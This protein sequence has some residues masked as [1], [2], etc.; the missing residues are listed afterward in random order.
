VEHLLECLF[1]DWQGHPDALVSRGEARS[2]SD[3]VFC[4]KCGEAEYKEIYINYQE[5]ETLDHCWNCHELRSA[6]DGQPCPKCGA[7]YSPF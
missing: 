4:P 6:T 1:C 7:G 3:Y 5:G 2:I